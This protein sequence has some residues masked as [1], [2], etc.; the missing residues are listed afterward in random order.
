MGV[1]FQVYGR[2]ALFSDPITR[3]GGEKYSYSVPTYQAIK[4]ICESIYWKP[5]FTWVVDEIRVMNKIKTQER[6]IKLHKMTGK[7]DLSIYTYLAD[8][9]YQ[10][11]AHFKFDTYRK[12]L[13]CDRDAD[14]H[15]N[16]A[17]RAIQKGGRRDIFLGTRECQGYVEPVLF[18]E[19][20][21]YYDDALE[22]PLGTMLHGID[23]PDKTGLSKMR[24]RFWQPTMK[25]GIISFPV[26]EECRL[27]RDLRKDDVL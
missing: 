25:N 23:Y 3:I 8:V 15:I 7:F 5:T 21:G 4:G 22:M 13:I 18:G 12:D 11:R 27:V 19:D 9:R 10:V 26:P 14:K 20:V 2:M 24:V 17:L 16:C 1:E 6:S